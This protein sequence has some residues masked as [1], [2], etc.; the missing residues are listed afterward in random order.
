MTNM[1]NYSVHGVVELSD[2][3][4]TECGHVV[5]LFHGNK[6]KCS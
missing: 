5:N 4:A 3:K 2:L 6:D 1:N